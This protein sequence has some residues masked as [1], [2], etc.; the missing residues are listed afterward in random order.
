M[1]NGHLTTEKSSACHLVLVAISGTRTSHRRK[2]VVKL[3][4]QLERK[5]GREREK[6]GG[7]GGNRREKRER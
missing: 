2:E 5:R 6:G 3:R 7:G 1:T 4:V